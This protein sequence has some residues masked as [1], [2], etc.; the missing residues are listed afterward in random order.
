[1]HCFAIQ[2]INDLVYDLLMRYIS[3]NLKLKVFGESWGHWRKMW[4]M[5]IHV[6]G[7]LVSII[8]GILSCVFGLSG[9]VLLVRSM[10]SCRF[11]VCVCFIAVWSSMNGNGASGWTM[12]GCA[13]RT[14]CLLHNHFF[15]GTRLVK[16]HWYLEQHLIEGGRPHSHFLRAVVPRSTGGKAV[17]QI[18]TTC[19]WATF[20]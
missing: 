15:I 7:L 3:A 9:A 5:S 12:S 8:I 17:D 6:N 20:K 11:R 10:L 14:A 4:K 19:C 18:G 16:S 13:C 2:L 1:M